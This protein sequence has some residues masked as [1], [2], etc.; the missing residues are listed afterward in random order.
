MNIS[1]YNIH[2]KGIKDTLKEIGFLKQCFDKSGIFSEEFLTTSTETNDLTKIY[3]AAIKNFDYDILLFDDSIIQFSYAK[4]KGKLILKYAYYQ[5]PFDVPT[6][7]D[8]LAR[9]N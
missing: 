7:S 5:N 2:L 1:Q 6:Y 8:F 4:I 3:V 9:G